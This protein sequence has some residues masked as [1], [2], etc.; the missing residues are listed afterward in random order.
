[1]INEMAVTPLERFCEIW[2]SDC[3][4]EVLDDDEDL[5]CGTVYRCPAC[6]CQ[7]TAINGTWGVDPDA[8]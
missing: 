5:I 6:S 7:C 8:N 3:C 4:H 1:M 2:V